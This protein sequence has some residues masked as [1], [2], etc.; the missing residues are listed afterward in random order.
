M[1]IAGHKALY[2]EDLVGGEG[3]EDVSKP[4][5]LRIAMEDDVGPCNPA[6]R[7]ERFLLVSIPVNVGSEQEP[8][9]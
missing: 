3:A 1:M 2:C 5:R 6:K 7:D 4:Q 9:W 8:V